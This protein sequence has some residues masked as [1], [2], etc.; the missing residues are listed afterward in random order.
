MRALLLPIVVLFPCSLHTAQ[1]PAAGPGAV[2]TRLLDLDGDGALDILA[3]RADGTLHVRRNAGARNFLDVSQGLPR[4]SVTGVLCTDLDA[5][6]LL[7]LYLVSPAADVVLHGEG[8]G[9]FRE[10]TAELGLSESGPGIAAERLDVDGDG[11]LDLV[12]HNQG[13]DVLFWACADGRFERDARTSDGAAPAATL[14][15][16]RS[17]LPG[18]P[19]LDA[20]SDVDATGPGL[21]C[22]GSAGAPSASSGFRA[23]PSPPTPA[24]LLGISFDARYVNDDTGEV[25]SADIVDGSLTGADVSTSG[26]NVNF[27][28]GGTVRA[29]KGVFG[30]SSIASGLDSTVSGGE[31]NTASGARSAVSGGRNNFAQGIDSTVAGGGN[32]AATKNFST[33][34][35]GRYNIAS[36]MY[37]LV[38]G[39]GGST[40]SGHRATVTGGY[41]NTALGSYSFA[42][43]RR[44]KANHT[45]SFVWGD[46]ANVD[47]PSAAAD[48]FNIYAEGG[49]RIFAA[50]QATP[51]LVVDAAGNIGIGTP[52]PGFTFEVNG[53]AH[54]ADDASTW[55]VTSDARLKKNVHDIEGALATLLSLR[56]VTFEYKDPAKPGLRRGFLAQEVE[57]VLPEWVEDSADGYKR[58]TIQ[59][60]EAL[61]VEALREQQRELAAQELRAGERQHEL[62]AVW[63]EA[64]ALRSEVERLNAT[65]TGMLGQR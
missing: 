63:L 27:G 25:D 20:D 5:D 38:A 62:E 11:L 9:V 60:F 65:L 6:G 41:R 32:N 39:G 36:G 40:A 45:G 49:A 16:A 8:G 4:V 13:S 17:A 47:K 34:A 14:P 28:G 3:V 12:L 35:G 10:A 64:A 29:Q 37:A 56:G 57:Q 46:S 19:I 31:D 1:D 59:G 58:L 26:G 33:V 55:T 42:A 30:L 15:E 22:P 7:D 48:Q 61:A 2:S 53:L 54:R 52:T 24:P 23:A 51:S 44:A 43:G 18:K 50:G 21:T